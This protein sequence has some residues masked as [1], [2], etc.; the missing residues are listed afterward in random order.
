MIFVT[1]RGGGTGRGSRPV[2]RNGGLVLILPY[3]WSFYGNVVASVVGRSCRACVYRISSV[4]TLLS[5]TISNGIGDGG[6]F[7]SECRVA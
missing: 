3:S 1:R 4:L 7:L 2:A 6:I 5:S